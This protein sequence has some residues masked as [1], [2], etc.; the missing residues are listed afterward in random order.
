MLAPTHLRGFAIGASPFLGALCC[1]TA[2]FPGALPVLLGCRSSLLCSVSAAGS[3]GASAL[4]SIRCNG[5]HL[6]REAADAGLCDG[7][8]FVSLPLLCQFS[9][10][11]PASEALLPVQSAGSGSAQEVWLDKKSCSEGGCKEAVYMCAAFRGEEGS[12]IPSISVRAFC[13]A[14]KTCLCLYPFHSNQIK[15]CIARSN[16]ICKCNRIQGIWTVLV[17]L[18]VLRTC[19]TWTILSYLTSVSEARIAL[20][21]AAKMAR[22]S[23][24]SSCQASAVFLNTCHQEC[25]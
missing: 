5:A 20:F 1:C 2:A 6:R 19:R 4:L 11:L 18:K 13:A 8:P 14:C 9:E 25:A 15:L 22:P 23:D 21:S 10:A 16:G 3:A 12:G 17:R 24:R 7:L